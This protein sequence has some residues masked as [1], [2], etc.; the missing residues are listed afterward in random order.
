MQVLAPL[1]WFYLFPP[2]FMEEDL[3]SFLSKQFYNCPNLINNT[4]PSLCLSTTPS[5]FCLLF[6]HYCRVLWPLV[7]FS[8]PFFLWPDSPNFRWFFAVTEKSRHLN[9]IFLY[10]NQIRS[11]C[12]HLIMLLLNTRHQEKR[13]WKTRSATPSGDEDRTEG[14]WVQAKKWFLILPGGGKVC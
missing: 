9:S 11:A 6:I 10:S 12:F 5:P 13:R 14:E 1:L 8:K 3:Y 2:S 4:G 7:I